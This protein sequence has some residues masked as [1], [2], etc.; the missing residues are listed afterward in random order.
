MGACIAKKL[1]NSETKDIGCGCTKCRLD[2]A[3]KTGDSG[4]IFDTT[5]DEKKGGCVKCTAAEKAAE[6][7]EEKGGCIKCTAAEKLS[8]A[9]GDDTCKK[10][11]DCGCAA[12]AAAADDKLSNS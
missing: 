12:K 2:A 3:K 9:L 11:S 10:E 1:S 7:K 4:N 5:S 8:E 6:A